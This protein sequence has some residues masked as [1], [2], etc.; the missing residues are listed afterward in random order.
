MQLAGISQALLADG[1]KQLTV[2]ADLGPALPADANAAV[3]L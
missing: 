1:N 2:S 3:T